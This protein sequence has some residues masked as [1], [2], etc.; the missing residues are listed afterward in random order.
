LSFLQEHFYAKGLRYYMHNF[1]TAF[2][3]SHLRIFGGKHC[4]GVLSAQKDMVFIECASEVAALL[5]VSKELAKQRGLPGPISLGL[6]LSQ[7]IIE[8]SGVGVG[9]S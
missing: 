6:P 8:H 7:H 5:F 2:Q 9:Q 4:N 1:Y 3:T